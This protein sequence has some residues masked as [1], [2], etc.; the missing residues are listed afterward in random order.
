MLDDAIADNSFEVPTLV[1]GTYQYAPTGA[2][3]Q[4]AGTAGVAANGSS[5]VGGNPAAP[6]GAQVAFLQG[7]GS[8]SQTLYL[9]TGTYDLSFQAAQ[10]AGAL[11][12]QYQEFEVLVDGTEVGLITPTSSKYGT[13]ETSSFTVTAGTHTVKFVGLNPAGGDNTALIDVVQI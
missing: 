10:R 4:F 9:D 8:M 7:T 12:A 13:Y 11:Q 1:A 5:F 3:W 6:D 2:A